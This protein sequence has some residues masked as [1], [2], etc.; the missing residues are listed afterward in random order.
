MP[1]RKVLEARFEYFLGL[2]PKWFPGRFWMLISSTSRPC[3]QNGSQGISGGS[4]SAFLNPAPKIAGRRPLDAYF[5]HFHALLQNSFQEALKYA[6]LR[7]V[8]QLYT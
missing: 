6:V 1:I 3:S 2:L 4:F 8:L 5:Q 7:D